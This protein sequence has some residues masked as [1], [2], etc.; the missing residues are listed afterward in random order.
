MGLKGKLFE[1]LAEAAEI[2]SKNVKEQGYDEASQMALA[3]KASLEESLNNKK[4]DEKKVPEVAPSAVSVEK[5]VEVPATETKPQA[6]APQE[7]HETEH[8]W[9][10]VLDPME[11]FEAQ[12]AILQQI[13]LNDDIATNLRLLEE[14]NGDLER[15]VARLISLRA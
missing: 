7:K 13:G 2:F 9:E 14:E 3:I 1:S 12:I 10:K 4:T 15:V 6:S 11:K 8:E 5:K